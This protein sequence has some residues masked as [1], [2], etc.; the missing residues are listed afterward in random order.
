[1][2]GTGR[3]W[4][5]LLA[6]FALAAIAPSAGLAADQRARDPQPDKRALIKVEEYW[7][8]HEEDP[9]ALETILASDF[10]HALPMGFITKEEHIDYWRQAHTPRPHFAK[11]FEDLR[12]RVYGDV[13]IVN[14][15]VV[16]EDPKGPR[17]TI[18]TDVFAYR[19][20]HWQAVNAQEDPFQPRGS[21]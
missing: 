4:L 21:S 6:C 9:D 14:G 17:K 7:L 8:T 11:H 13:G 18:F 20:G 19:S 3:T 16:A 10:V 1:M 5:R 2:K 12:V 15:V